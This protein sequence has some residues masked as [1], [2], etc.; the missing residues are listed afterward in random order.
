M[1]PINMVTPIPVLLCALALVVPMVAA[2]VEH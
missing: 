1:V 2:A